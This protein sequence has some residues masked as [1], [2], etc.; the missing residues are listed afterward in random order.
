PETWYHFIGG[1]VSKPGI[2]ADLEAI[3]KAGISGIQLFHGQFGGEWPGVSPQIQTLSEDWDELVQWTAEECKRL[4]LRFTMQNCPGW[5]Y[6]GGPWIE[7]ENS[8]RH[9]VY[10]RTDLAGGVA[11]EITLA[12]PG[13]IE[14]EWRDYRDLFVIAF[15]T[16]EGDTG[17]R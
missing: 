14:E 5:S 3:A 17:A 6:A 1:N 10:S 7:P 11:S 16:P 8:M 2:T 15:P 9:L 12:K 13:N 4:N